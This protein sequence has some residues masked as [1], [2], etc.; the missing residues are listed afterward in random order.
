MSFEQIRQLL[1]AHNITPNKLLGQN[2]MI[3][4]SYYTKLAEY[5][6]LGKSDVVLD[7]GA[8]FGFLTRFLAERCRGVI[9]VEKDPHIARVLKETFRSIDN[10]TVVEGDVL[11]V[12]LPP[13]NKAVAAPPYYLSSELVI[14]L[15][16]RKIDCAVLIVQREFAERLVAKV[17]S[18][19]YGWLTVVV[20]QQAEAKLL[21]PVPK[22]MFYPPPD[23]ES[24]IVNIKPWATPPF[25]VKDS[26]AFMH[27][28]KWLFT[29]RNR[30][31]AKALAPYIRSTQKLSKQEAEK[32]AGNFPF[33]QKRPRELSP[34]DFGAIADALFS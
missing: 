2:F 16:N 11:K 31:L 33:S 30:K 19:E 22:D 8:G 1:K 15:L 27:L 28:A 29:Q 9:A 4:P 6:G 23:V 18:E 20:Q 7:I 32:L 25:E 24:V 14:W 13:F 10:V 17:G 21:E 12:E 3:Q 26:A 5:A 34:K